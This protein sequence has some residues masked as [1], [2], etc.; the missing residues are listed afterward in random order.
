MKSIF[1]ATIFGAV[2]LAAGLVSARA[3]TAGDVDVQSGVEYANHDGVVLQGELYQPKAPGKYPAIVAVHGGGWQG[4]ARTR[5][6]YGGR[7]LGQ[8]GY[9]V[10]AVCCE[11]SKR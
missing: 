11:S 9:V 10:S 6:G 3:Q 8:P 4:G 2:A 5:Y 7:Y 1:R